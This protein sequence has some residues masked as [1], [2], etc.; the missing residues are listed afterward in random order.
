MLNHKKEQFKILKHRELYKDLNSLKEANIKL[1]FSNNKIIKTYALL[2]DEKII[3][4]GYSEEREKMIKEIYEFISSNIN[5]EQ[6]IETGIG[7]GNILLLNE[8]LKKHI[9]VEINSELCRQFKDKCDIINDNIYDFLKYNFEN[10]VFIFNTLNIPVQS[11]E[12]LNEFINKF[13]HLKNKNNFFLLEI[14]KVHN[15]QN[16]VKDFD[17]K[18]NDVHAYLIKI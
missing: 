10:T 12:T 9:I 5:Y 16:V 11:N 14:K 3:L 7:T 13:E 4:C 1:V 8:V 17:Y 15:L 6:V 18:I 2:C